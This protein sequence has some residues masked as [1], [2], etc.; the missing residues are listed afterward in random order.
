MEYK[1]SIAPD[2]GYNLG[3]DGTNVQCRRSSILGRRD[4][5]PSIYDYSFLAGADR[6]ALPSVRISGP[7]GEDWMLQGWAGARLASRRSWNDRSCS[8]HACR[9]TQ[10]ERERD[11]E[12]E[13]Q[14][15]LECEQRPLLESTG[16]ISVKRGD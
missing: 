12:R 1:V 3:A 14:G 10:R 2:V 4:R 8:R 9:P 15:V 7:S 11:R 6:S 5:L 13:G 16:C